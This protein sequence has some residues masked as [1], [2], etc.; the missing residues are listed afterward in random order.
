MLTASQS[1]V[2]PVNT[3][4]LSKEVGRAGLV[5]GF[6]DVTFDML[7]TDFALE[8]MVIMLNINHQTNATAAVE[9]T[10]MAFELL[11]E[12]VIK[13]E[14]LDESLRISH[15]KKFI[16]AVELLRGRNPELQLM[17]LCSTSLSVA[18]DLADLGC[19]LLRVM[20]GPIG[21]GV[22]I[23]KPSEF[24]AI[25]SLDLPVILD[26]G[27][28]KPEHFRQA[29]AL[30]AAGCLVNSVLFGGE[31]SPVTLIGSFVHACAELAEEC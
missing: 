5:F 31:K 14:V 7:A 1:N 9:K 6:G 17:P 10:E 28:G 11:P 26:G 27:V 4:R 8:N 19:P 22:G 2:L 15:D 25:C 18:R 23:S 3:H 29:R 16:K 20:G 21:S 24:E 13:I 30:G 12:K